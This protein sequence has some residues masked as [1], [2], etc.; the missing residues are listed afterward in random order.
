MKIKERVGDV[1]QSRNARRDGQ[2]RAENRQHNAR[3]REGLAGQGPHAVRGLWHPEFRS[4]ESVASTRTCDEREQIAQSSSSAEPLAA[5][6]AISVGEIVR[7]HHRLSR[8]RQRVLAWSAA[9][10]SVVS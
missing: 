1:S 7:R 8:G 9:A 3:G 5:G 6:R 4:T 2:G 10:A